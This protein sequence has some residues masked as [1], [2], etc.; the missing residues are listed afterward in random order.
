MRTHMFFLPVTR[1]C[2]FL[3]AVY[4]WWPMMICNKSHKCIIKQ[5]KNLE[6]ENNRYKALDFVV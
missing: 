2:W 3:P 4:F 5:H 6:T 1:V